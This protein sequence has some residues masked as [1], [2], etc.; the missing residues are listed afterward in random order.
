MIVGTREIK[1]RIL[2]ESIGG[3]AVSLL[4]DVEVQQNQ[5]HVLKTTAGKIQTRIARIEHFA[6]GKLLGLMRLNDVTEE[7]GTAPQVAS[8]RDC[9]FSTPQSGASGTSGIAFGLGLT[10]LLGTI[11]CG[12][13]LYGVR[14]LPA[15]RNPGNGQFAR[16]F[17]EAV[18]GEIEKAKESAAEAG[19]VAKEKST[20]L[21]EKVA[22]AP[23]SEFV[24]RQARVS[25]EVLYRLQLTAE[26]SHQ[27]RNILDRSSG[28]IAAAEAD[29]RSVLTSEQVQEWQSLAP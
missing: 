29:I 19:R 12:L 17:A 2:D 9:L 1:A 5:V 7:E 20:A 27:I 4:E 8:W 22:A 14:N 23:A 13:G 3:F 21:K 18:T 25:A 10:I 24:R 11:V 28:D 26:Q 16:E 15:K 6:D